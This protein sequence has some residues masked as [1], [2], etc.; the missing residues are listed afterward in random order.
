MWILFD[1]TI[2]KKEHDNKKCKQE[3]LIN[4]Y[5]N[6]PTTEITVFNSYV[7]LAKYATIKWARKIN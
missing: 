7:L 1:R 3:W 5:E 4:I 6:K 2:S